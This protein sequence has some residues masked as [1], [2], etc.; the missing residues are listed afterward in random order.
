M[1]QTKFYEDEYIVRETIEERVQR[2]ERERQARIAQRI[3]QRHCLHV[4]CIE[5]GRE[6]IAEAGKV[7]EYVDVYCPD[8][9]M[10]ETIPCDVWMAVV[11]SEAA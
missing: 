7:R 5:S 3:R 6:V 1:N 11:N 9:E 4:N 2:E 8:C 10:E